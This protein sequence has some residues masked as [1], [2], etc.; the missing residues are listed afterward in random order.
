[1]QCEVVPP[2]L[3]TPQNS[4]AV[5]ALK[6]FVQKQEEIAT[7]IRR[8]EMHFMVGTDSECGEVLRRIEEYMGGKQAQ[9]GQPTKNWSRPWA[10]FQAPDGRPDEYLHPGATIYMELIPYAWGGQQDWQQGA[11]YLQIVIQ[12]IGKKK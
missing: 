2:L 11:L 9:L 5:E 3:V 7:T 8:V 10:A 4:V 1:M 6:V 12:E